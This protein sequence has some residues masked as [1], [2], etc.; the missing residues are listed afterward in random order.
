[1]Q[2]WFSRSVFLTTGPQ[3]IL[4]RK[5][6]HDL[7]VSSG[8]GKDDMS[9]SPTVLM[10][11]GSCWSQACPHYLLFRWE[12]A[13]EC[14]VCCQGGQLLC[15]DACPRAFHEDCH[16]PPTEAKRLVRRSSV[17]YT[18]FRV[19]SL[20]PQLQREEQAHEH[21]GRRC[22]QNDLMGQSLCPL[23]CQ[24]QPVSVRLGCHCPREMSSPSFAAQTSVQG[25]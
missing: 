14:E 13:N 12:N 6:F 7:P 9:Q 3:T 18:L 20:I 19:L 4:C 17:M 5:G 8:T 23:W 15:C 10:L 25:G 1:M 2:V 11:R 21:G 22:A 16:I 24:W